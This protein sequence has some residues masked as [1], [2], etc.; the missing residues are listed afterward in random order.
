MCYD[1]FVHNIYTG[2]EGYAMNYRKFGNTGEQISALGFG[3]MRF[4]EYEADG[5]HFVDQDKVDKMIETA[6]KKG[7]NYLDDRNRYRRLGRQKRPS[8][9]GQRELSERPAGPSHPARL[10]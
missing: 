10:Q 5:K 6:Y 9:R 8:A 4:P 7:V 1:D 3:C 2:R